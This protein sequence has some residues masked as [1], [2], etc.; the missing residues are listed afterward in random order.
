MLTALKCVPEII[1]ILAHE[2]S[3]VDM[4]LVLGI[5]IGLWKLSKQN[6]N[7]PLDFCLPY[8]DNP[9][10]LLFLLWHPEAVIPISYSFVSIDFMLSGRHCLLRNFFHIYFL[11]Y[12]HGTNDLCSHEY[13]LSVSV[14][15][16]LLHHTQRM[17]RGQIIQLPST[18]SIKQNIPDKGI[19]ST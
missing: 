17:D 10:V 5:H 4:S 12:S 11:E 9:F 2:K 6:K 13:I 3:W 14:L 1:K 19:Q 7:R 8:F 16:Y 15:K 18:L